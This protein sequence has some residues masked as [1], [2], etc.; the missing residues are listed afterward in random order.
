MFLNRLPFVALLLVTSGAWSQPPLY[1]STMLHPSGQRAVIMEFTRGV[2]RY[3]DTRWML[4]LG[5]DTLCAD[6]EETQRALT[7][8]A[9]ELRLERATTPAG[10]IFTP[11]VGE[12]FR[13]KIREDGN[14]LWTLLEDAPMGIPTDLPVAEVNGMLPWGVGERLWPSL[15]MRLPA[16]PDELEYRMVGRD[17]VLLDASINLVVDILENVDRP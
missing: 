1:G 6:P 4:A 7:E 8:L 10:H 9:N 2:D 14:Q 5:P 13:Q 17:L 16:L 11:A 12:F 3:M 15:M